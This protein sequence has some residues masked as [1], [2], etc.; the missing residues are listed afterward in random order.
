M[1]LLIY[2]FVSYPLS[3][4][5]LIV[6]GL[7]S[8]CDYKSKACHFGQSDAYRF[9]STIYFMTTVSILIYC[10]QIIYIFK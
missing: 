6:D 10:L 5:Q 8:S 1:P 4:H 7:T 3:L 2:L 9:I